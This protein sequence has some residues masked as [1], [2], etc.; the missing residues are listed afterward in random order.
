MKLGHAFLALALTAATG[1]H[2]VV[3]ESAALDFRYEW[4]AEAVAIPALDLRLYSEAKRD[5]VEAQNGA[6]DDKKEYKEEGRGSVRDLYLTKWTTAGQSSRLLSLRGDYQEYTGGAHPNYNTSDLLWDRQLGREIKLGDLFEVAD[7]YEAILRSAYCHKLVQTK[8]KR[9]G[10]QIEKAYWS[11]PK[12]SEVATVP[13][14]RN[15]NGHFDQIDFVSSPYTAG[16]FAEGEYDIALRVT[17]QLIA[18]FKPEY[19][20]SFE[21]QRQ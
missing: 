14:D 5:L 2:K 7:G 4:P 13:T 17:P 21:V 10:D 19:R 20:S 16:S 18:A 11:C 15:K 8:V 3:R 12:F 1:P 9:T 6:P